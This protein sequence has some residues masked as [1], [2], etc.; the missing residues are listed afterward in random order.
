MEK[1]P[2]V[3]SHDWMM[4]YLLINNLSLFSK[5]FEVQKE[6]ELNVDTTTLSLL[7]S[8][9]MVSVRIIMNGLFPEVL[10]T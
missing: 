9:S 7:S 8:Q 6:R 5:R 2:L 1:D 3:Y 10:Q 4:V